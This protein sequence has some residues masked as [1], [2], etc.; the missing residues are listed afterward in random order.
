M[1]DPPRRNPSAVELLGR[2]WVYWSIGVL[3][4]ATARALTQGADWWV[5]L[6]IGAAAGA[7]TGVVIRSVRSL[8]L[9]GV[10]S[11]R[12]VRWVLGHY[13]GGSAGDGPAEGGSAS[14]GS[15]GDRDGQ[16]QDGGA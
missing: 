9:G 5:A 15:G 8:N 4:V 12:V 6:A 16:D 11:S 2:P 3:L 14:G 10:R 13:R 7:V 1:S